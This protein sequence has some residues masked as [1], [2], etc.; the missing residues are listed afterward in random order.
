LAAVAPVCALHGFGYILGYALPRLLSFDE[1]TARTVSIETGMQS[2]AMGYALAV[3]HFSDVM[4]AV[5]VC[6]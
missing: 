6:L 4:V 1:R 2:A 5:P 3:K